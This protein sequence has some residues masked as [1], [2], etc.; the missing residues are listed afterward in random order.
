MPNFAHSKN[1]VVSLDNAAGTPVDITNVVDA[2]DLSESRATSEVTTLADDAVARLVGLRDS[3]GSLGGPFDPTFHAQAVALMAKDDVP[4]TL[5]VSPVGTGTGM[6][7]SEVE[8]WVTEY[9]VKISVGDALTYS[10]SIETTGPV[11][12]GIH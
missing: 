6:P 8:C 3:S 9:G 10:M 7:Y 5:R 11:T 1:A 2:P 4:V 12:H